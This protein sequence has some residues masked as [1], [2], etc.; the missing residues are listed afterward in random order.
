ML[1]PTRGT[2]GLKVGV[3]SRM[4]MKDGFRL[5]S[6]IGSTGQVFGDFPKGRGWSL[7]TAFDFYYVEINRSN[8]IMIE[9]N[10]GFKKEYTLSHLKMLLKPGAAVGFAYLSDMG[11]LPASQYLSFHL[12]LESH[13]I[14]D[15]K[16]AWVA[17]LAIFHAPIG[18]R[19]GQGLSFGPGVMLRVGL[20][21]R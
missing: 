4:S 7:T 13:F 9:P 19:S 12:L 15:I 1:Q 8:Q 21:F 5:K 3:I 11:D 20:A 2:F 14:I 16:K 6:E 18:R 17:E 10:V